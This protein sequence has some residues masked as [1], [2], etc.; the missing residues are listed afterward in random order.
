M[1]SLS[2]SKI[3]NSLRVD[4]KL[5]ELVEK[6]DGEEISYRQIGDYIG[7]SHSRVRQIEFDALKKLRGKKEL[8]KLWIEMDR[9]LQENRLLN[10]S[11]SQLR[12]LRDGARRDGCPLLRLADSSDIT[13]VMLTD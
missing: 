13:P 6:H 3:S 7:L 4:R 5:R 2:S 10:L 9:C 1:C 8:W 11:E 12:Q